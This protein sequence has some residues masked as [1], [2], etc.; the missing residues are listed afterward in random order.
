M[1]VTLFEL[2]G[3]KNTFNYN[4][5]ITVG[6]L[7]YNLSKES[8]LPPISQCKFIHNHKLLELYGLITPVNSLAEDGRLK[9]HLLLRLSA[10]PITLG[11][12]RSRYWEKVVAIINTQK[13]TKED[14]ME[15]SKRAKFIEYL[16]S[17]YNSRFTCPQ[18]NTEDPITME[19]LTNELE[20]VEDG[21]RFAMNYESLIEYVKKFKYKDD[22]GITQI[23]N[24]FTRQPIPD[25]WRNDFLAHVK[26]A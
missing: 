9:V 1:E 3:Q 13:Y 5:N 22:K 19:V 26:E 7:I 17:L 23:P 15:I 20:W 12:T 8:Q 25:P 14:D 16:E 6:Q 18:I 11:F 4:K 2:T 10:A 21:K 24:P